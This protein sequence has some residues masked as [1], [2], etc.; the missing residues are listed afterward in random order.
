MWTLAW[1]RSQSELYKTTRRR[2]SF[3]VCRRPSSAMR[4]SVDLLSDEISAAVANV[5]A[6]GTT[7]G[8]MKRVLVVTPGEFGPRGDTAANKTIVKAWAVRSLVPEQYCSRPGIA[9]PRTLTRRSRGVSSYF[10]NLRE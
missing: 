2:P 3:D 7:E 4:R 9:M 8:F 1:I 5:T 6:R 10:G